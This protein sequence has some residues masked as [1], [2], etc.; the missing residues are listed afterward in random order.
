[1]FD[2]DSTNKNFE[3]EDPKKSLEDFNSRATQNQFVESF[4]SRP[5]KI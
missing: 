1:M 2:D 4:L 3:E 5:L